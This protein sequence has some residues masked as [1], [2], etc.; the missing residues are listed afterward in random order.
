MTA[1]LG[2][3]LAKSGDSVESLL[4]RADQT[5]YQAKKKGKNRCC[6]AV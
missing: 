1:S 2:I 4:E 5:L 3:T 6:L